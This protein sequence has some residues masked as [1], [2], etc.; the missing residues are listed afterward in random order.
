MTN[1]TIINAAIEAYTKVMGRE[2]WESL[3]ASQQHDAIMC[4][5]KDM[6][7]AIEIRA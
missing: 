1:E 5:V 2:K 6:L 7:K 4:M 3:T